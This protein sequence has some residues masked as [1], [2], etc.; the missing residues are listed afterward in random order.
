MVVGKTQIMVK[1]M[2]MASVILSIYGVVKFNDSPLI[3]YPQM[4]ITEINIATEYPGANSTVV[5]GSV[6]A[7]LEEELLSLPN[8]RYV[9][10]NANNRGAAEITVG[11]ADGV[12]KDSALLNVQSAVDSAKPR[13]PQAVRDSGIRVERGG[14]IQLMSVGLTSP[15]NSYDRMA[16]SDYAKRHV[17]KEVSK[18]EGVTRVQIFGEMRRSVRIWLDPL[19]MQN[20][21]V[22]LTQVTDTIKIA[23]G[24]YPVGGLG[25]PPGSVDSASEYVLNLENNDV[26][27]ADVNNA[28]IRYS[29][30]YAI[31]LADVADIEWG[32]E[33][34]GESSTLNNAKTIT[35]G[36]FQDSS[37]NAVK[38]SNE[39]QRWVESAAK[40]T[41][42]GIEIAIPYDTSNFVRSASNE[43]ISALFLAV[44]NVIFV[45]G[46]SLRS[47]RESLVPAIVIPISLLVTI[48]LISWAGITLNLVLLLS[49]ILATGVVVDDSILVVERVNSLRKSNGAG[50]QE[51][52]VIAMTQL[53]SPIIFTTVILLAAFVPYFFIEGYH[54][55]L[56]QQFSTV[57]GLSVVI[58]SI[59]ALTLSP[60]LCTLL[61]KKD[62]PLDR[63]SGSRKN[64][65]FSAFSKAK[66]VIGDFAY[67]CYRSKFVYPA[68]ALLAFISVYMF[69][70][71]QRIFVPN[72]D[73]GILVYA[74]LLPDT[75]PLSKT[76]EKMREIGDIVRRHPGVLSTFNVNGW[77]FL[78]G[79]ASSNAISYLQLADWD[80][81]SSEDLKI[82]AVMAQLKKDVADVEG[83]QIFFFMAPTIPGLR[84]FGSFNFKIVDRLGERS[85]LVDPSI[86]G[87][88]DEL[89]KLPEL[90]S[91]V[92]GSLSEVQIVEVSVD[93]ERVHEMQVNLS[94]IY[95]VL[96]TFFGS[97]HIS[98]LNYGGNV[99][100]VIVQAGQKYRSN[101]EDIQNY[102][103]RNDNG[104]LV[105]LSNF[106]SLSY[107]VG[108]STVYRYDGDV[109]ISVN[110]TVAVGE[111]LSNTIALIDNMKALLPGRYKLVWSNDSQRVKESAFGHGYYF[112]AMI[113][114]YLTLAALYGSW[115]LP[116]AI[117]ILAI[118]PVFGSV[119]SLKIYGLDL[120]IYSNVGII[121]ALGLFAKAAVLILDRANKIQTVGGQHN[122]VWQACSERLR[123]ILMTS[124]S[125][126]AG[127]LP[128]L[129]FTGPGAGARASLAIPLLGSVFFCCIICP[130]IAPRI[131]YDVFRFNQFMRIRT[132]GV[133]DDQQYMETDSGSDATVDIQQRQFERLR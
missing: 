19:R 32:A 104:D 60:Y 114:I 63:E 13:L 116:S 16:L 34:Y 22:D 15:D 113:F 124:L 99:H 41:P 72:E 91:V 108:P 45:V 132:K 90:E 78:R 4:Q 67:R 68:L 37:G 25:E 118:V 9:D 10:S 47:I 12:D 84:S 52:I 35:V 33:F 61:I 69:N 44:L 1:V 94:D 54:G 109:S 3:A 23:T 18:I 122:A 66:S 77:N 46:M 31:T 88:L 7:L 125:F 107:S 55:L 126:L 26:S 24:I 92:A 111:S 101:V 70:T 40:I 100:K 59:V 130:F 38:I 112:A 11:F 81:R 48:T 20:Y 96:Q 14:N 75:T 21:N 57:I 50:V 115:I 87:F 8:L 105:A 120:N 127:V 128:I 133:N 36:V 73:T 83:A 80:D 74:V 43:V 89:E 71:T 51:S 27:L 102:F 123:P 103:V 119:V 97:M 5:E 95:G 117:A 58:S 28:I 86:G 49:M 129:L 121:L 82:E 106:V 42:D 6:L 62:R 30:S 76:E 79:N 17:V 53:A 39:V 64:Y 29:D 56:Y 110:G 85:S 131:F 93:D 65:Y 2:L 98:D